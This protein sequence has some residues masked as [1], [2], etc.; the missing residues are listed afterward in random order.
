MKSLF[1]RFRKGSDSS[2]DSSVRAGGANQ[3]SLI[4]RGQP[5]LKGYMKPRPQPEIADDEENTKSVL[6]ILDNPDLELEPQGF[7]PY[8]SGSFDREKDW[9]PVKKTTR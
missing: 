2:K 9:R 6:D 8:N 3:P 4:S 5:A 1:D 7:N